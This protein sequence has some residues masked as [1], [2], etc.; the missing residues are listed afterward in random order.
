MKILLIEDD[1]LKAANIIND[2]KLLNETDITHCT[3]RNSGLSTWRQHLINNTPFEFIIS[4]NIMPLNENGELNAYAADITKHIRH[5]KDKTP[6]CICS[7]D[8]IDLENIDAN[9]SILY[10][11]SIDMRDAWETIIT[12]AYAYRAIL[13]GNVKYLN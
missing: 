9:Y 12:D 6:I 4:D 7:S 5:K 1:K 11:S 3:T 10:D 8:N 13:N 2:L